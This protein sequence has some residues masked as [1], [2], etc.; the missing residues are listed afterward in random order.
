MKPLSRRIYAIAAIALAA[1]IFVGVNIAADTT[2]TTEQLDLTENGLY[3]L[4]PGTKHI[5]ENLKE[6]ITLKFYYSKKVAA[7]YAQIQSYA[8]RVRDLLQRYAAISGG[9]IIVQEIDPEPFTPEEDEAT[10]AGLSA[11]PTDS[12][13]N[14]YF[15]LV[16]TNTIDGKETIAFFS[17]DR[18]P[19]LEY[20][21]TSLIYHLATPK[22]PVLGIIT[23]LPMEMGPGGMQAMMAG[24][25]QP[26]MAYQE[27]QASYTTKMLQQDF[28]AIPSDVDV[29]MIA[30]PGDLTDQQRYAID[31][32]V[33]K[34]GRAL[35]FVDPY[36]ELAN[37]N[38]AYDPN[39]AGAVMSD[40]PK[41]FKAWGISYDPAKVVIDRDLAQRVQTAD[42]R[43]PVQS[44][45]IWLKLGPD[46][47]DQHDQITA[48]LQNLNLASAGALIPAKGATTKFSPLVTTSNDASLV[49]A[50][51][52]RLNPRPQDLMDQIGPIGHQYTL[53]A[54]ISGPAKTAFPK[55]PP[56]GGEAKSEVKSAKDINVVVMADADVFDDRFWVHYDNL[57]GKRIASPFADNGAFIL[58]AVENL[59]GSNDLISLRTRATS[60]RPFVVVRQ[61]QADAQTEFQQEADTL[62]ARLTDTQQRLHDLEQGGGDANSKSASLTPAQQAEIQKFKRD[63]I[64]TRSELRDVQ[65]N[66]RKEV[67]AL[68]SFLAFVNIALVPI[69]VAL[70]ALGLAVIRR[71]RRAR[72]I[73]V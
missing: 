49:D 30:H 48:S 6:P 64:E 26:Y 67:D 33:L 50:V 44:Y 24:Q 71:R 31:Q 18:E 72:A 2:L 69:L 54:R 16:G 43:N 35:V 7:D 68:G 73:R 37:P 17:Q 8:D 63:L 46:Q 39:G 45:P 52:V 27:L 65:H 5:I 1:V 12:G 14:V 61:L 28:T 41:L 53:A 9:K 19:F 36:A 51:Q 57:F 23:S 25:A 15:G 3:T 4:S 66:L 58:N 29:L 22:K 42:Q 47:F 70:F 20:D 38:G 11:A 60:D 21:V 56:D 40:L 34:G 62:Q 13:D 59:T 32:F 10:A 55:G